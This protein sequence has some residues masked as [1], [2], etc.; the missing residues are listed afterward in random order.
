MQVVTLAMKVSFALQANISG[1][2]VITSLF[3]TGLHHT[4]GSCC[5]T[6]CSQCVDAAS[7]GM[8][9]ATTSFLGLP[10]RWAAT[11]D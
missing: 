3:I 1:C 10:G 9:A 2:F 5:I 11:I 6:T 4:T 8:T 7:L